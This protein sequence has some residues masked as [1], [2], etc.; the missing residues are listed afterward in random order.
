MN[1]TETAH[2]LKELILRELEKIVQKGTLTPAELECV[3]KGYKAINEIKQF[4]STEM[5]EGGYSERYS[6]GM[7]YTSMYYDSY[8]APMSYDRGRSVRTG[9][10]ISRDSGMSG[11]SVKDRAIAALESMVDTAGSDYER[12]E[13]IKL[14]DNIRNGN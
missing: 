9:R 12:Q 4:E 2:G 3:Y 1:E 7:P 10:Y 5:M 13:V 8:R 6:E 11:H 14:I